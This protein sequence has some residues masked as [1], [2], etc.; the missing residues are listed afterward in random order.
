[1]VW[2]FKEEAL[3]EAFDV[4]MLLLRPDH[5]MM[6]FYTIEHV[7]LQILNGSYIVRR[8]PS[9]KVGSCTTEIPSSLLGTHP[10]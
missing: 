2:R 3:I 7:V 1:M 10:L 9:T 6:G 8:C 5:D 4:T